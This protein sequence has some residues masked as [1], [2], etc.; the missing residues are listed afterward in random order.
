M[1][2]LKF[3]SHLDDEVSMFQTQLKNP[4][5]CFEFGSWQGMISCF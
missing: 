2:L 4:L 3:G 5:E 1:F